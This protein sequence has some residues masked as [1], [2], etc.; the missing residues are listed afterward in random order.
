MSTPGPLVLVVEDDPRMRRFLRGALASHGF[1]VE[2]AITAAEATM[3]AASH[4][5]DLVLLDLGLPD[6]DGLEVVTTLRAKAPTPIVVVSARGQEDDKVRALD[7]GADDYLTKPFGTAELLAR[8]RVALRHA[9]GAGAAVEQVHVVGDVT[10]D[11][12]R[13]LVTKGDHELHL[14][15]TEYRLLALLVRHAGRVLTHRQILQEVWG[16]HHAGQTHSVRVYMNELRKK[17]ED[18]PARPRL[19]VTEPGVG[20]R[21]RETT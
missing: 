19:L 3:L 16:P 12:G 20:Y 1:R 11:L 13:R 9:A 7:L 14:T 4:H 6:R 15:P 21:L 17:I 5:P 2:E 10:V 8:M 18:D